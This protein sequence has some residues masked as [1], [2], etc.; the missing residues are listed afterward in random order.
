[1]S[2][3]ISIVKAII[4][5]SLTN[6]DLLRED[7]RLNLDRLRQ[8]LDKHSKPSNYRAFKKF[9]ELELRDCLIYKE[10][11]KKRLH[12]YEQCFW[13]Y[14]DVEIAAEERRSG[15]AKYPSSFLIRTK[16]LD[17]KMKFLY[18]QGREAEEEMRRLDIPWLRLS[19]HCLERIIQR[20]QKETVKDAI[21]LFE[22]VCMFLAFFS[23]ALKKNRLMGKDKRYPDQS[24]IYWKEGY[25][26]LKFE[27]D[28]E[29]PILLT[30]LP[31]SWFSEEQFAKFINFEREVTTSPNPFVFDAT[32]FNN[33]KV[34]TES[35]A[36]DT[37]LMFQ[38]TTEP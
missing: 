30:W 25:L 37:K 14:L 4:K 29:I 17:T 38:N 13:A 6:E 27:E 12:R 10:I 21:K 24:L 5:R 34:L 36:L 35:D 28:N 2:L 31:K 22:P 23:L 9:T 3:D 11:H 26:I 16:I 7:K 8:K 18:L 32:D 1:M 19:T 15:V 33:K 20:S